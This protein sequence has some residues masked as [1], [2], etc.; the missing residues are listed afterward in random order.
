[1]HRWGCDGLWGQGRWLGFRVEAQLFWAL[2]VATHMA[3]VPVT[4]T[5]LTMQPSA[6]PCNPTARAMPPH[7]HQIWGYSRVNGYGFVGVKQL[8]IG[9]GH[10]CG[11]WASNSSV[12]CVGDNG[13]G[14]LGDGSGGANVFLSRTVAVKGLGG[15][16]VSSICAG[17]VHTCA[18]MADK[19]VKCWGSNE[20]RAFVHIGVHVS[21]L[22]VRIVLFGC[23]H[24]SCL[25]ARLWRWGAWLQWWDAGPRW[26]HAWLWWHACLWQQGGR[27]RQ[28][29]GQSLTPAPSPSLCPQSHTPSNARPP[30]AACARPRRVQRQH[31]PPTPRPH[32][33]R[34]PQFE[35]Q[36]HSMARL[37]MAPRALVTARSPP[38][39]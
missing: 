13:Y 5:H 7:C 10:I 27:G 26:W 19:T 3:V 11:L 28:G 22:G 18:L 33:A 31:T 25:G 1:M 15:Q 36:T 32:A 12:S 14:Q 8:A 23:V 9:K 24:V 29:R 17:L 4:R 30:G 20:V 2:G 16:A 39:L 35:F 21:S 34:R 37:V 38:P 6:R